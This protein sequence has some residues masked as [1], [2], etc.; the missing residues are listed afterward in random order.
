MLLCVCYVVV[1]KQQT[2]NFNVELNISSFVND[3]GF[4]FQQ[5]KQKSATC[6][7]LSWLFSSKAAIILNKVLEAP[8]PVFFFKVETTVRNI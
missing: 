1:L 2:V 5:L 6:C 7:K 3:I 8:L 4:L